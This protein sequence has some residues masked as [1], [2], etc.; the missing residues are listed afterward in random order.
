MQTRRIRYDVIDLAEKRRRQPFNAVCDTGEELFLGTCDSRGVGGVGVLVNASLSMNI[1]SFEQLAARIRRLRLKR[2]RSIPALTILA[3]YAPKSYHD[4]EEVEEFYMDLEKFYREDHAFLKDIIE[5][6]NAKI[7]P[8]RTSHWDPRLRMQRTGTGQEVDLSQEYNVLAATVSSVSVSSLMPEISENHSEIDGADNG[9]SSGQTSS[10]SQRTT[11][12]A[13]DIAPAT[14]L[15]DKGE[16]KTKSADIEQSEEE[17]NETC[18]KKL[19]GSALLVWMDEHPNIV[20][21]VM[22]L[23][24]R[25]SWVWQVAALV[26]SYMREESAVVEHRFITDTAIF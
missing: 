20:W 16:V 2:C 25:P 13:L 10:P 5:D 26:V 8:R 9:N 4:E 14:Q 17:L 3:V 6:F 1:D 7:G 24:Q 18:Y 15:E 23:Q 19:H 21:C 11:P 12:N 22:P